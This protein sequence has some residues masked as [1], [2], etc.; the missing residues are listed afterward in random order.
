MLSSKDF[1]NNVAK[2]H[3]IKVAFQVR[4]HSLQFAS[5]S[6]SLAF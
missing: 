1:Q 3:E 6:D 5:V 2:K 4:A